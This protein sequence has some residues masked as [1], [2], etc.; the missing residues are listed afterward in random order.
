MKKII[1]LSLALVAI[2]LSSCSDKEDPTEQDT[3]LEI[4]TEIQ[5]RST[6]VTTKFEENDRMMINANGIKAT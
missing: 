4:V 1:I 6:A 2:G 5:A 3:Y